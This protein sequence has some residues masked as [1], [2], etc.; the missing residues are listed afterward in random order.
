MNGEVE[1]VDID[2]VVTRKVVIVGVGAG[3]GVEVAIPQIGIAGSNR[4]GGVGVVVEGEVE[5]I[6][7]G[8]SG[9]IGV[10]I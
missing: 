9:G 6:G 4:I 7:A 10:M 3:G 1:R 8:A 5:R 2:A